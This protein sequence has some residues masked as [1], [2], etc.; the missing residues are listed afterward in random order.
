MLDL[1]YDEDSTAGADANFVLTA[2][3]G[4]VEIQGTAEDAP[5]AQEQFHA[6]FMLARK[7]VKELAAMQ[8]QVL[9]L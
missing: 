3:D 2:S 6:L 4:I 9:G 1:D 7:G 8:R 5:F